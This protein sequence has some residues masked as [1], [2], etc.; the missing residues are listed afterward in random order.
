MVLRMKSYSI[1]GFTEKM[2][3]WGGGN[4]GWWWG[5]GKTNIGGLP[6]KGDWT[7]C[8]FKKRHGMA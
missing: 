2:D 7:F 3:L 5:L 4:W 8:R 6:K 1:M